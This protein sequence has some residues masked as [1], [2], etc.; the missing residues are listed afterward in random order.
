MGHVGVDMAQ[1]QRRG[2]G[3]ADER[4]AACSS[5]GFARARFFES[6]TQQRAPASMAPREVG[7]STPSTSA[8]LSSSSRSDAE[9]PGSSRKELGGSRKLAVRSDSSASSAAGVPRTTLSGVSVLDGFGSVRLSVRAGGGGGF[10]GCFGGGPPPPAKESLTEAFCEA[11]YCGDAAALRASRCLKDSP[12]TRRLVRARSYCGFAHGTTRVGHAARPE[13]C[14]PRTVLWLTRS[15]LQQ[16]GATPLLLAAQQGHT[17]CVKVLLAGGADVNCAHDE[18]RASRAPTSRTPLLAPFPR[19][20]A[21]RTRVPRTATD[22]HTPAAADGRHTAPTRRPERTC[23]L[24]LGSV[25]RRR[26]RLGTHKKRRLR[27]TALGSQ[28]RVSRR[29][30]HAARQRAWFVERSKGGRRVHGRARRCS[31]RPARRSRCIVGKRRG[32]WSGQ[33]G[34]LHS[35]AHFICERKCERRRHRRHRILRAVVTC[36]RRRRRREAP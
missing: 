4:S 28:S 18:V 31:V 10:C 8:R 25:G 24:R 34:G 27:R 16:D 22:S 12:N 11:S 13:R 14:A 29:N 35:A 32:R 7:L 30:H 17:E 20:F 5:C 3:A 15:P 26:R 33:C 9:P 2:G 1:Q 19:S 6:N 36:S 23:R 21:A